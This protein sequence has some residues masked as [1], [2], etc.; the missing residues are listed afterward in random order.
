VNS[1]PVSFLKQCLVFLVVIVIYIVLHINLIG[2]PLNRDE[3]GF[4]YLGQSISHGAKL[5]VDG[6]D[7]KPPGIFFVYSFRN[8]IF[9]QF[10]KATDL[11]NAFKM[12]AW[13]RRETRFL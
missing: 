12:K 3:G 1:H 4:A 6:C 7:L 10:V 11:I 2:I 5:Y 8:H 9:G 13:F